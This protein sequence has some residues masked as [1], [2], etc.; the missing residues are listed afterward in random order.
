MI[1]QDITIRYFM[2]MACYS[3]CRWNAKVGYE[4]YFCKLLS[5]FGVTVSK[6]GVMHVL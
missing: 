6:Q 4:V 1:A 2:V 5:S 3:F